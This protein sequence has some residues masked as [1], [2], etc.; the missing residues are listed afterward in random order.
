MID[1][2]SNDGTLLGALDES[3]AR[4][5]GVDPTAEQFR[6]F[7]PARARILPDFFSAARCLEESGG[8]RASFVTSIA[9]LYDLEEPLEFFKQVRDVLADDGVWFCEQSYLPEMLAKSSYDTVCHEHL[10]YYA[11]RQ[12]AWL[13]ERA[14]M[15][16]LDV[17]FSGANGGSFAV[18]AARAE[19]WRA[20]NAARV[21]RI[22]LEEDRL[23]LDEDLIYRSFRER[24]IL[25][26]D[27]LNRLLRGFGERGECVLGY[28][29]STKG[30][31]ILQFCGITAKE[32]PCIAEVNPEKFGC[33]TPGTRIPIVSE[34]AAR[35]QSPDAFL[36]LPWH[37]RD[38]IISRET[39]YL[40]KGGA[41]IFPLPSIHTHRTVTAVSSAGI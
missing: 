4:L 27:D 32:L 3:G 31:V 7:Y 29:A 41:L 10:E 2:G 40:S 22:L 18:L 37:F 5:M 34:S 21:R 12:I 26:R 28:G 30:N 36:V 14:G 13:V 33:V 6:D 35:A 1:V 23:G 24:A 19:S 11:L 16:I 15:R 9:M 8:R 39:D 25:H 20:G 17:S 38:N